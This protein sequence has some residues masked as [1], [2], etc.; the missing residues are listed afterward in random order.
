MLLRWGCC[1][2]LHGRTINSTV[3]FTVVG[4]TNHNSIGGLFRGWYGVFTASCHR[5]TASR[6]GFFSSSILLLLLSAYLVY[7][8]GVFNDCCRVIHVHMIPCDGDQ[9]ILDSGNA[10]ALWR[11]LDHGIRLRLKVQQGTPLRTRY[12]SH[13]VFWYLK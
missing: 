9:A 7:Y 4:V 13:Q 6:I 8:D 12:P 10:G 2:G 11:D 1:L 5:N 3:A